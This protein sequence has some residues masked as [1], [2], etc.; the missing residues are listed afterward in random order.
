MS[1]AAAGIV[2][3]DISSATA[4]A[5][6]AP[7]PRTLFGFFDL[8]TVSSIESPLSESP[9]PA[10]P[11]E[12]ASTF[13][14]FQLVFLNACRQHYCLQKTEFLP[15]KKAAALPWK[16]SPASVLTAVER[17]FTKLFSVSFKTS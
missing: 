9:A 11:S 12:K 7:P 14:F 16:H 10:E 3:A 17:K 6:A 5:S 13:L 2:S 8:S 4:S 15:L 1:T